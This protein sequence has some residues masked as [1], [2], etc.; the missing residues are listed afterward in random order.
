MTYFS[1]PV[2]KFL[3]LYLMTELSEKKFLYIIMEQ[4]FKLDPHL[5]LKSSLIMLPFNFQNI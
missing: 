1:L 3:S 2:S 5:Y 4:T